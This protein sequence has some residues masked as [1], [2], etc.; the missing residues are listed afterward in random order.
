M[1]PN[2]DRVRQLVASVEMQAAFQEIRDRLT[3]K[4]MAASTSDEERKEA[5]AEYRAVGRIETILTNWGIKPK[6]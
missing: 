2:A 6:E 5:L 3:R 4:V 1:T